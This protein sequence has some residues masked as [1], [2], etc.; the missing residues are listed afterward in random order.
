MT[1]SPAKTW[2]AD[3]AVV[4]RRSCR[5]CIGG[6]RVG[7]RFLSVPASEPNSCDKAGEKDGNTDPEHAIPFRVRTKSAKPAGL[8]VSWFCLRTPLPEGLL[9]QVRFLPQTSASH[10]KGQTG[11][12]SWVGGEQ[13]HPHGKEEDHRCDAVANPPD[14]GLDEA[15]QA[16]NG[17]AH[18]D[19]CSQPC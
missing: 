16:S 9:G 12:S 8:W 19:R 2:I 3:L 11:G 6:S 4:V 14:I 15:T 7:R 10:A 13:P 1:L 17:D 18:D 5:D